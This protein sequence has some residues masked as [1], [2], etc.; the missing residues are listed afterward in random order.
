MKV[1]IIIVN[2]NTKELTKQ[3]LQSVFEKTQDID[4]EVIVVDNASHDGSQ[5]MLKEEFTNVRLVENPENIGFGRANNEGIKI[6]KGQNVFL[7]NP[8]TILINNAVKT[9]SDYLDKNKNVAICGGNLFDEEMK[10]AHSFSN[11]FISIFYEIDLFTLNGLSKIIYGKNRNF[12]HTKKNLEVACIV[13]ADLM[14]KKTVFDQVGGFDP[15]FF[16]YHE[17]QE[18]CL[19]VKKNGY[20]IVSVPESNIIHLEGKSFTC[21]LNRLKRQLEARNLFYKKTHSSFYKYIADS[22]F[23]LTAITRLFVFKLSNNQN[24]IN[25]WSFM[26]KN[27]K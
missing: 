21:N 11:H 5:K 13:G 1:S 18:L 19:R 20:K 6:A 25:I 4:F 8:D 27:I 10:P 23:Y 3:C 9:L 12:N 16:M 2:Y 15:D 14:I 26:L 7:L 24:K 17:E 22:I